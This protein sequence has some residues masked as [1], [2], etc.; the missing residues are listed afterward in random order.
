MLQR[1]LLL[2]T[3]VLLYLQTSA[4]FGVAAQVSIFALNSHFHCGGSVHVKER[5][6]LSAHIILSQ[7]VAEGASFLSDGYKKHCHDSICAP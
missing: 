7:S 6:F 2:N 5:T 4:V 3:S 1:V